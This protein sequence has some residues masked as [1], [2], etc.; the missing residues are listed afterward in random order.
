VFFHGPAQASLPFGDGFLCVTGGVVR[1]GPP[2]AA[3][4]AGAFSDALDN[5]GPGGVGVALGV[6]RH[7]QGWYRDPAGGASGFNLSNGITVVFGP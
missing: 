5:T 1:M 4:S 7:F 2:V 6:T 3:D